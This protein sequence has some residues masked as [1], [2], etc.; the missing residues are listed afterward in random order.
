MDRPG[1][2]EF[3]RAR[4]EALQPSDVGLPA[5]ARRRTAGL[6]REEIAAVVGMSADYWARL[7]QR[8]GPQPSDQMLTAIA[9][10]LR[11]GLDERDH[12]F[13]L[14]GHEAPRRARL[15]PHVSPGLMRVLDRLDDTPALVITELGETLA[16]NRL[17][18]A[19]FGDGVGWTGLDRSGIHR[20][21]AH[22]EARSQY[23]ER[24]HERQGRLQV[25]QL[26]VAAS[27]ADPDPLAARVVASLLATSDEFRHYWDLQEVGTRFE[28]HKTL[29]HPEVGEIEVHCQALFTEDQSQVL[30][31]LTPVPGSG[32]VEALALL[33]V[34]GEQRFSAARD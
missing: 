13:R 3:L 22:P 29:Q 10:G 31:V 14:A 7:E 19:V 12:L 6:R 18:A 17:A 15:S 20:W 5:G 28:E 23:P 33:G 2:A 4:R 8:R 27:M 25:A 1:L 32:A 24:D 34:V 30:L 9:R 11:L 21:F 16:Q 26:R